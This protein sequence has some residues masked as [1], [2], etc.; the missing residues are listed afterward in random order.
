[1]NFSKEQIQE[2]NAYEAFARRAAIVNNPSFMM[3]GSYVTRQ[4]FPPTIKRV[5]RD[6]DWVY[7]TYLSHH[8]AAQKT[9]DQ[10][11][12][13]V[14]EV[15]LDDGVIFQSFTQN[16]FWRRIDYAMADDFPTVNT[17]LTVWIGG[18][19][20]E[21]FLDVSFNL[22]FG[23]DPIAL[24]YKPLTGDSFTLPSTV[25]L[26]LQIS[27]KIHQTLVRP[28]FKDLFDLMYLVVHPEF[29][30]IVLNQS[31]HFLLKEC[32]SDQIA[33][34][35]LVSFF[36]FD[37]QKLFVSRSIRNEWSQWRFDKLNKYNENQVIKAEGSFI[38]DLEKVSPSLSGFLD[39]L[40]A[41]L[42][43]SG[44]GLP[45]VFELIDSYDH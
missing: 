37:I 43:E 24:N 27:W 28:R 14:T 44:F 40:E 12:I 5:P 19:E 11:L 35:K 17:D 45:F 23:A 39:N 9:F 38:T 42:T 34:Q 22:Q 20:L 41:I 26:S 18:E 33:A 15:A 3:K 7:L 31:I 8:Q 10:W 21:L 25:P 29:N 32:E 16:Q 13:K 2:I 1:M 36:T 4:Y 30:E 6:L